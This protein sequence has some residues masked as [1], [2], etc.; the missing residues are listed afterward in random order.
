MTAAVKAAVSPRDESSVESGETAIA[1]G[2]CSTVTM[3]RAVRPS[4]EAVSVPAPLRTAVAT[5]WAV[6]V[7]TP[8]SLLDQVTVPV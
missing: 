7:K 4:N 2:T 8:G 1:T 6:T 3:A 5:P